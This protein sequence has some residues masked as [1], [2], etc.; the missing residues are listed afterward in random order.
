MLRD[1]DN[2]EHKGE[3]NDESRSKIGY[4]AGEG[5]PLFETLRFLIHVNAEGVSKIVG[6]GGDQEGAEHAGSSSLRG[7]KARD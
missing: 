4:C 6:D 1:E 7:V 2:D 3:A 5:L